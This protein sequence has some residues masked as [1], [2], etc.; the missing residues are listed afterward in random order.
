MNTQLFAQ[1]RA[2]VGASHDR[3]VCDLPTVMENVFPKH[4][5]E[6]NHIKIQICSV[7][8]QQRHTLNHI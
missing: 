1:I 5:S 4:Q 3:F 6:F 7:T 8:C 2:T